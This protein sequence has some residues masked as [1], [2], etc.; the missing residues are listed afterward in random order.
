MWLSETGCG[1]VMDWVSRAGEGASREQ[2]ENTE[3]CFPT[4]PV[5]LLCSEAFGLDRQSPEC[6]RLLGRG[7]CCVATDKPFPL[8]VPQFSHL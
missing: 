1:V 2:C 4:S 7:H 5:T 3:L 8:S 6:A